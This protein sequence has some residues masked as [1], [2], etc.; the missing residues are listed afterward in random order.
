MG[1]TPLSVSLDYNYA[2]PTYPCLIDFG[3]E[4]ELSSAWIL[5]RNKRFG[6]TIHVS[7]G[8]IKPSTASAPGVLEWSSA[9]KLQSDNNEEWYFNFP[10]K[11]LRYLL[12]SSEGFGIN[13]RKI[14]VFGVDNCSAATSA[15][16]SLGTA[17]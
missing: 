4:I 7:V 3:Q 1:P 16:I 2:D 9:T 15:T 17:Y 10:L 14:A 6:K 8:N 11:P 5:F 13:L 12:I